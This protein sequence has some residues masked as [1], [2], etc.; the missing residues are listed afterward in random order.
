[1]LRY[2]IGLWYGGRSRNTSSGPAMDESYIDAYSSD[3][4]YSEFALSTHAVHVMRP[5][6]YDFF[7]GF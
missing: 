4:T 7:M 6:L 2:V 5:K 1:M 3:P